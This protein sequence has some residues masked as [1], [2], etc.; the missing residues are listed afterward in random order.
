MEKLLLNKLS[1]LERR[2]AIIKIRKDLLIDHKEYM[3]LRNDQECA[4]FKTIEELLKNSELNEKEKLLSL[5]VLLKKLQ[6][7]E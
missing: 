4:K 6:K 7:L 3:R 2:F 1:I 5:E